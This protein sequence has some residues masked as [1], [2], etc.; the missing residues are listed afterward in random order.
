MDL[1]SYLSLLAICLIAAPA[2]AATYVVRPDGSGDF[3]TI[4]AA[5]DGALDGD[6]IELA[7]GTFAGT[8]NRDLLWFSKTLTLRSQSGDPLRC[9]IDCEGS[10]TAHHSALSADGAGD[11]SVLAGITVT[12]GYTASFGAVLLQRTSMT[13]Q[14]CIFRGNHGVSGGGVTTNFYANPTLLRCTFWENTASSGGAF[15]I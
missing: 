8:G 9:V 1:R 3:P 12:G 5:I 15:C 14:D 7:D 2:S 4:Q 10:P 11:A 13:I 6:I